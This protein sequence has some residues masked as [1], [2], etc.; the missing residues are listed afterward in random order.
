MECG[1]I[2][3]QDGDLIPGVIRTIKRVTLTR[4]TARM[5]WSQAVGMGC[6]VLAVLWN[7]YF[8][9]TKLTELHLNNW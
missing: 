1:G 7:Y 9:T 8:L 4:P 5:L 6:S 3:S 2:Q